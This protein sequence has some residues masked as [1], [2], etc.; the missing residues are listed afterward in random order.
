MSSNL[1]S[2]STGQSG[3][4]FSHS[5]YQ[6]QQASQVWHKFYTWRNVLKNGTRVK[7]PS[8]M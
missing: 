7:G 1:V 6:F 3:S 2:L 4:T 8:S 5:S